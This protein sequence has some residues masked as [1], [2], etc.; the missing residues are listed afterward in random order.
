MVVSDLSSKS[1]YTEVDPHLGHLDVRVHTVLVL[2]V[3]YSQIKGGPF[4]CVFLDEGRGDGV[5]DGVEDF[6]GFLDMRE[7]LESDVPDRGYA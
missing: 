4:E 7:S 1:R 3:E 2:V 6:V 5:A